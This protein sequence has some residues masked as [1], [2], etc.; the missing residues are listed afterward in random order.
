M[1][2]NTLEESISRLLAS[3]K[4]SA[5]YIEFEKQKEILSQNPD[6]KKRVDAFRAKNY[7]IQSQCSSD[8]LFEVVEQM[9]KESAE[10]RRLPLVNAYLDAELALCKM[11]QKICVKLAEGID[12]DIPGVL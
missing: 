8:Q 5:E 1:E 12:M 9:G 3:I 11:M 7:R 2:E 10:L 6:L 4:E